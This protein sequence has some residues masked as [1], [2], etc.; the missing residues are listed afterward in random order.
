[1]FRLIMFYAKWFLELFFVI[2]TSEDD[3]LTSI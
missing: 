2:D 3:F 1:M